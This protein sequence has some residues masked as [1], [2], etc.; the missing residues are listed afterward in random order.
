[1][2][3]PVFWGECSKG[4]PIFCYTERESDHWDAQGKVGLSNFSLRDLKD[5]LSSTSKTI[6]FGVIIE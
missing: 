1:M 5:I 2:V 3:V 4:L 6:L